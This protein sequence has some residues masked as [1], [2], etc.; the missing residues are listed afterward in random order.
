MS[1]CFRKRGRN[2]KKNCYGAVSREIT[3]KNN[4]RFGCRSAVSHVLGPQFQFAHV[5]KKKPRGRAPDH[6]ANAAKIWDKV[7]TDKSSTPV[8]TLYTSREEPLIIMDDFMY[9]IRR[10][11]PDSIRWR[12]RVREET[13]VDRWTPLVIEDSCRHR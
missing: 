5:T 7:F 13:S 2:L 10:K 12:C 1:Y 9:I 8:E 3:T 6:A 11:Y 4:L